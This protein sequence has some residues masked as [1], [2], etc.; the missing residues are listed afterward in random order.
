MRSRTRIVTRLTVGFAAVL[1]L[2]AIMAVMAVRTMSVMAEMAADL[3]AHPFAVTNAVMQVRSNVNAMRADMLTL[4]RAENQSE[5]DRIAGLV[6]VADAEVHTNLDVIRR[7]YLGNP[8]DVA[9]LS[10]SLARWKVTRERNI[11]LARDGRF[12]EALANARK[13][14]APQ[15]MGLRRDLEEI[16]A[17]ALAKAGEFNDRIESE[18]K[19]ALRHIALTL[20]GLLTLG[21]VTAN[22]ITR[23]IVAPLQQLR[24]CMAQLADGDLEVEIPNRD[25]KNEEA[26]MGR[27]VQVFK[28]SAQRIARQGWVKDGLS[29]LTVTLQTAET[30]AQFGQAA[31]DVLV[32]LMGAGLGLLHVRRDGDEYFHLVAGWGVNHAPAQFKPGEG[33]AG[34]SAASGRTIVMENLPDDYIRIGSGLGQA[35]P[36]VA[37]AASI[38]MRGRVLAV[39]ELAS[40]TEFSEVQQSLLAEALPVLALNLEILERNQRTRELLIQ[41]QDQAAELRSSEEELRSQSDAIQSTNEE[42]RASE[43]ELRM[44]QEALQAANEE[45]RL[46]GD[47]LEERGEALEAARVEADRRAVELDQASRYKSEFLA[48]MSHELR[49]PLNSLLILSKSLAENDE[50]N[51]SEDQQE[52]AK[53]V[54]ESGR[55]LLVLI[56]DILDLSKVEAGKMTISATD[57]ALDSLASGIRRRFL[58]VADDKGLGLTIELAEDLPAELRGD[59]GKIEQIVNNLVGNALKFTGQGQVLVRLAHPGASDLASVIPGGAPGDYLEL[60]VTDSGIGIDAADQSRIFRAFEQVDGGSARHYGGTG[61]GLTISR[62]LARLMGGDVVVKSAAGSGSTFTLLIPLVV[63]PP[64]MPASPVAAPEPRPLSLP[65]IGSVAGAVLLVVEDDPVFRSIVCNLAEKRGFKTL[66]AASGPEGVELARRHHPTGIVLDIGL[67]GLDGWGVIEALRGDPAT[68]AIP[69]HVISAADRHLQAKE[70][71]AVGFLSKP[72]AKEQLE[73]V[74]ER[75]L[76]VGSAGRKRM[77]LVDGDLESV[78]AVTSTL[79]T[80]DLDILVCGSGAAALALLQNHKFDCMILDPAL[81]DMNGIELLERLA[82][83][84]LDSPCVIVYSAVELSHDETLR[85]REFTDSIVIRGSRSADRLVDEVSLFLHSVEASIGLDRPVMAPLSP[86][87]GRGMAGKTVLVVDDDMRSAFALSKVLRSKGLKVLIAQDGA[88]AL[89]QL[90][91]QDRIDLVLMDIMMPGMDGYQTMSQIRQNPRFTRLPIIALTAKAMSGDRVKCLQA[92]ADDYMAKPVDV[93]GLMTLMAAQLTER[94]D[95]D[96]V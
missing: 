35:L 81:P 71:G 76:Q 61:L 52:S 28:E 32:P 95:A 67:P 36:K 63:G 10:E 64:C 15:Y 53:V 39:L 86:S 38:V 90:E 69:V 78:E 17:F 80:L 92:G 18:R 12:D 27:A 42:L 70:L 96:T 60:A 33:L 37:L 43:E 93:D 65:P 51:L 14:G 56:N 59:R 6:A 79:G 30:A 26:E 3:Y 29:S 57:I 91:G 55:S 24:L 45:L 54:F 62:Q 74:F 2:T 72:A 66:A 46:K 23:S 49:T 22:L 5:V 7:Q 34:Q 87:Q 1:L 82:H 25:G 4:M 31:L 84:R 83:D 19:I 73:E 75:L 48:N 68:A 16:Y 8:D 47:A 41:T 89:K 13:E 58:P 44:Q 85:I 40:F 50:G 88:K 20:A 77:L 9:L 11:T 21:L 94:A